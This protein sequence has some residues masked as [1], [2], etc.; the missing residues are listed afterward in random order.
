MRKEFF[1]RH[2]HGRSFTNSLNYYL[3]AWLFNGFPIP[4]REPGALETLRY[5]GELAN[6]KWCVLIFP[7]GKM[8]RGSDIAPFQPGVGMMASKLE[9][10]VV[11]IRIDGLNRVLHP[12]WKMARM[13]PVRIAF[14]P[15][16]RVAGTNYLDLARQVEAAVRRL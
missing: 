2:F 8:S 7:E 15:P 5:M 3:S 6:E 11:P 9:I 16:L 10:P 12:D 1:E 14:G 13:A 4:Q